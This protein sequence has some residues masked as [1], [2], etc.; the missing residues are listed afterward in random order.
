M[1]GSRRLLSHHRATGI[2]HQ[3]EK[4][5]AKSCGGNN[6]NSGGD[7]GGGGREGGWGFPPS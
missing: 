7:G 2:S 5:S 4:T 1:V 3:I 6:D